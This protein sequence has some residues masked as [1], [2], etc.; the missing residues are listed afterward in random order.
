MQLDLFYNNSLFDLFDDNCAVEC[1]ECLCVYF[2]GPMALRWCLDCNQLLC[3]SCCHKH[4]E[5]HT[6]PQPNA[7]EAKG[8][9]NDNR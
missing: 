2:D 9:S 8:K 1:A 5:L 6:N 7:Y 4:S 3:S